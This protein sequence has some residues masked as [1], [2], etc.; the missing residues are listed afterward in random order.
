MAKATLDAT[1][2]AWKQIAENWETYFSPPSRPS[3]QEVQKYKEWV[4]ELFHGRQGLKGLVL[5]AT[6]ELRDIFNELKFQTHAI[7]INM[8]MILALEGL[9]KH[10]NPDEVLIK[11][12]WL[13]NPLA[14]EY[15]DVILGD[16]VLP[17]IP[18][19]K[20][21]EFYKQIVRLLKPQGYFINRAFFIPEKKKYH[22]IDEILAKFSSK[23]TSNRTALELVFE[24]Q[25][26]TWD[27]HDHL[28]SMGKV[29]EVVE[30]LRKND[31][32][33][34]ESH[35]LNKTLNIVWSYWVG[36]VSK[37]VWVYPYKKEE[38]A[39]YHNYFTIEK[40]FSAKDHP[41]GDITPMYLLRLRS[42]C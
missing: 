1:S 22:T 21:K 28:G 11:A 6:P 36:S 29:R 16:A 12:N 8:E 5:G 20:R 9:V 13:T 26:L 4:Q 40:T 37:K 38:E 18:W 10:K 17:N 14:S 19:E 27:P 2:Y 39:E 32:F 41:Y 15:F 7:D 31:G 33:H 24:I 30:K 35:E 23:K 42:Q 25:I 3:V 34:Y